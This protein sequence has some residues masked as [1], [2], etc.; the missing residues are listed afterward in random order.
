[1]NKEKLYD[2]VIRLYD[3]EDITEMELEQARRFLREDI[4]ESLRKGVISEREA[5]NLLRM[6]GIEE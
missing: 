2:R 3:R 6:A 4:K 5:G 1:M